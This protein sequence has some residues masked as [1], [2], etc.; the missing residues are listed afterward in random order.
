MAINRINLIVTDELKAAIM[1]KLTELLE[2]FGFLVDLGPDGRLRISKMGRKN[3][4]FVTRGKKH[5]ELN[6]EYLSGGETL[7]KFLNDFNGSGFLR[8]VEKIL[9]SLMDKVQDTAML[10]ES[11]AYR[12]VRIYYKGAKAAAQG[13]D[14]DQEAKRIADDLAVHYKKK[15][16]S[17]NNEPTTGEPGTEEPAAGKKEPQV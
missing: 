13:S 14:G 2:L 15:S 9:F 3:V 1:Q 12:T 4:D 16:N 11:E 6:P 10:A 5:M 7:E 8:L 17:N